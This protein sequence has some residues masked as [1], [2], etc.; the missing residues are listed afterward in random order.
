[1]ANDFNLPPDRP[2]PDLLKESMWNRLVPELRGRRRRKPG[3]PLAVAAGVGALAL[4]TTMVFS[5]VQDASPEVTRVPAGAVPDAEVAKEIKEC[6]DGAPSFG[7][8]LHDLGNWR[9]TLKVDQDAERSYLVFRNAALAGVCVLSRPGI[10]GPYGEYSGLMV[11]DARDWNHGREGYAFLS[12]TRPV[13]SFTSVVGRY[14]SSV[15]FGVASPDVAK[16]ELYGPDNSLIPA[17]LNDGTFV[18]KFVEGGSPRDDYS[19][20]F[21]VT[22]RDGQ[23]HDFPGR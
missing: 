8:T 13:C 3:L 11:T 5:P 21:R 14:Q 10:P 22:M 4:S 6:L 16:V 2:M 19:R 17:V 1:M 23:V 7:I 9:F 18:V 12:A 15:V 20:K